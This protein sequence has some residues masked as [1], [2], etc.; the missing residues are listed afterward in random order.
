LT[1]GW[2]Q[3]AEDFSIAWD[4]PADRRI[5]VQNAA[6]DRR[7]IADPNLSLIAWRSAKIVN[8]LLG[9]AVYDVT[10]EVPLVDWGT[11]K[12]AGDREIAYA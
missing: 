1:D 10:D 5:Y 2:Y 9:R 4:G 11:A 3:L 8:S 6:R 7:G 12:A